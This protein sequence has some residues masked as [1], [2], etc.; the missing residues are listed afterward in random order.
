MKGY[1]KLK[2]GEVI[3]EGDGY[4]IGQEF[5]QWKGAVGKVE[6]EDA[7]YHTFRP[8]NDEIKNKKPDHRWFM[9]VYPAC[10]GGWRINIIP[11]NGKNK[12]IESWGAWSKRS[13]A[14]N[15]ARSFSKQMGGRIRFLEVE[16]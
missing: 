13:L 15:F 4:F 5:I 10:T 11:P 12:R 9:Y 2:V 3:K 7:Y 1:R 14:V 16:K 6:Y 8:I